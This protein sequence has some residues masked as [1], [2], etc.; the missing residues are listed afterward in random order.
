MGLRQSV[1]GLNRWGFY[2]KLL[3]NFL[4][5]NNINYAIELPQELKLVNHR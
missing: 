5:A 2:I 1:N 4:R 3:R